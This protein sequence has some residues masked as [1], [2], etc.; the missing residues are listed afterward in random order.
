M[1]RDA[2][3]SP[4]PLR[5][6]R[7]LAEAWPADAPREVLVE[8]A[9]EARA[10]NASHRARLRVEVGRLRAALR[11]L[12]R[13]DATRR[14]FALAPLTSRAVVVLAP[15]VDG[16]SGAILALLEGGEPWSTSALACALGGS[17]RTVQRALRELEE[18]AAVRGVGR[19][20]S[21]R[22]LA[23]APFGFATTLLLPGAL[24]V[25]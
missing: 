18:S 20:R 6:R 17:Q 23:S 12:A 5:P 22:W 19:G 4:R 24:P 13:V 25:G 11:P 7:A 21:R 14:G 15:P 1:R 10:A 16:P 8:Q 2:R 9:F 3:R